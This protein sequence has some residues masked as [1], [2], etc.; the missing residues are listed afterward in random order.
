MGAGQRGHEA[1]AALDQRGRDL[2]RLGLLGQER[3]AER[4]EAAARDEAEQRVEPA[5]GVRQVLDAALL[6]RVARRLREPQ[7]DVDAPQRADRAPGA[8]GVDE[9][10]GPRAGGDDDRSGRVAAGRVRTPVARPSSTPAWL[11]RPRS[12]R[13][14]RRA[15]GRRRPGWRRRAARAGRCRAGRRPGPRRAPARPRAASR[16]RAPRRAARGSARRGRRGSAR[17]RPDPRRPRGCRRTR[18]G[19]SKPWPSSA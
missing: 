11:R 7:L 18:A 15:R 6:E 2:G 12:A 13:R 4:G 3:R 16:G 10:G 8:R 9:R 1:R 17:A 5:A 14:P 19:S